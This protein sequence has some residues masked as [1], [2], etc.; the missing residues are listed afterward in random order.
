MKRTFRI[1]D[2]R[3]RQARMGG[4]LVVL[5]VLGVVIFHGSHR[6]DDLAV[7]MLVGVAAVAIGVVVAVR[8]YKYFARYARTHSLTLDDDCLL[9]VDGDTERRVPYAC[10]ERVMLSGF[11]KQVTSVSIACRD[12]PEEQLEGYEDFK[13]IVDMLLQNTPSA[14]VRTRGLFTYNNALG[15]TKQ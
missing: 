7:A 11:L 9:F 6:S 3:L 13:Q 2:A 1:S 4:F 10:I 15:G 5:I 14:V 12:L 8:Q